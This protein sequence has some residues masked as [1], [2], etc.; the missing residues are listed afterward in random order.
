[1]LHTEAI[2][3]SQKTCQLVNQEISLLLEL[4]NNLSGIQLAGK[5][6]AEL[7]T[8]TIKLA[9]I[10]AKLDAYKTVLNVL[11]PA[12]SPSMQSMEVSK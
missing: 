10:N 4:Q 11:L 5:S 2:Q 9:K 12:H 1:M 3:L 8:L 7:N 6:P